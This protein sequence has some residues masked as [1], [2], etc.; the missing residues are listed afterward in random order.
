[1]YI[2]LNALNY[3]LQSENKHLKMSNVTYFIV[4]KEILCWPGRIRFI[5]WKLE[6]KGHR[7]V[8]R[9]GTE[10][11]GRRHGGTGWSKKKGLDAEKELKWLVRGGRIKSMIP[12]SKFK[13]SP[14]QKPDGKHIKSPESLVPKDHA[15]PTTSWK[16]TKKGR[17]YAAGDWSW[18]G[19]GGVMI[20]AHQVWSDGRSE[21]LL[22]RGTT[23]GRAE[24]RKN[25]RTLN[26]FHPRLWCLFPLC[27]I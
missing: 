3:C 23:S 9:T 27:K 21:P 16:R 10:A 1:M 7:W 13:S 26:C 17:F 11:G 19:P 2:V 5:V 25:E 15:D 8:T 14:V 4:K 18:C 20:E 12:K 24:G 22:A 6:L